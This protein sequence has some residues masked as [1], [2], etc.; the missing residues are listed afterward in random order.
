MMVAAS[1]FG[2]SISWMGKHTLFA[3]P[4]GGLLRA[5]GGIPI[6]RRSTNDVVSAMVALFDRGLPLTLVVPAEGTRGASE[7]WKSGFYH[8]ARGAS[9]PVVPSFLDYP[10]RR[11]G[12]GEPITLS[13]DVRADMDRIRAFYADKQGKHPERFTVPR[14]REE[15][16]PA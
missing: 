6:D 2:L 12:I 3:G 8:I 16:D 7:F 15:G 14:L 9:V 10:S 13:G 11:A 5:L 1:A 4:G